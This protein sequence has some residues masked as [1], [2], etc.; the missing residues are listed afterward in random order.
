[1]IA[2]QALRLRLSLALGAGRRAEA[3]PP[4]LAVNV[5]LVCRQ[6]FGHLY[7]KWPPTMT[8]QPHPT[9]VLTLASSSVKKTELR[10]TVSRARK[11]KPSLPDPL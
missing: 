2:G 9:I 1:M 10:S 3:C 4:A 6:L 11:D 5:G 8:W 7:I